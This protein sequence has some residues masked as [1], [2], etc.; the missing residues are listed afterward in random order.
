LV[1]ATSWLLAHRRPVWYTLLPAVFMLVTSITMLIRLL[2]T[3]YWPVLNAW[4]KEPVLAVVAVIVLVATFGIVILA[5]R[6]WMEERA[7]GRGAFPV[8]P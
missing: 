4:P 6:R 3:S 7:N 1:V 8:R 5:L 2:F